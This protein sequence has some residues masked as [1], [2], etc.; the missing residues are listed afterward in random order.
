MSC[1]FF[2][3]F[4]ACGL[5]RAF[6]HVFWVLSFHSLSVHFHC[7]SKLYGLKGNE[8]RKNVALL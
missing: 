5:R 1:F 8:A 4:T 6:P 3:F 2:G 7:V